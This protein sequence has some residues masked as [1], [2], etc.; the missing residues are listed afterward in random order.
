MNENDN[1]V[2]KHAMPKHQQYCQIC[3]K[4]ARE[5][6]MN[7]LWEQERSSEFIHGQ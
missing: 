3:M 4:G 6:S 5:Y 2:R 1:H 7:Y